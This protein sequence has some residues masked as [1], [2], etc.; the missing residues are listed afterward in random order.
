M[1]VR[2]AFFGGKI[3]YSRNVQAR[4]SGRRPGSL[5]QSVAK[6]RNGYCTIL[7]KA[8]Q[9]LPL[10]QPERERIERRL[11]ESRAMYQLEEAKCELQHR[12][13]GKAKELFREANRYLKRTSVDLAVVGL[14]IAPG[15]TSK[16]IETWN[17]LRSWRSDN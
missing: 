13:F 7:E 5:S 17:V 9:T 14:E 3:G 16:F 8:I 6:M 10:K 1:W 2:T 4:A 15:A 11:L 12:Q